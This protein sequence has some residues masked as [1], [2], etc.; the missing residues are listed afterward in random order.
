VFAGGGAAALAVPLG[1][2][3]VAALSA[4]LSYGI[5]TG[6]LVFAPLMQRSGQQVLIGTI[7]LAI[8]LQEFM[9]LAQGPRHQWLRPILNAPTAVV[10]A[11]DFVVTV[12]PVALVAAGC[13]CWPGWRCSQ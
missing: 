13:A 1:L 11:D 6:R 8:V 7:S 10:R 9:R 2:A 12:T 3:L 5:A 4:A